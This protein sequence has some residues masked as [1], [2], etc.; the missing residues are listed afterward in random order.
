[1]NLWNMMT[2]M[3]KEDVFKKFAEDLSTAIPEHT[4]A[5]LSRNQQTG[6]YQ[7]SPGN[8]QTDVP[9]KN[10]IDGADP[11]LRRLLVGEQWVHWTIAQS[12]PG[13]AKG[14]DPIAA[15]V[16]PIAVHGQIDHVLVVSGGNLSESD[17][18]MIGGYCRQ[19]ALALE[20]LDMQASLKL[21][22]ERLASLVGTVDDSTTE[23]SYQNLL[24]TILDRSAELLLAEQGSIMLIEKETDELLLE[25]SRGLHKEP[26]Q[27]GRVP[28]GIGIAG[29]V[30]KL[31][32]P[33]L[34]EDVEQ[35]PRIGK[36]NQAK[37]KTPSFVSVPLKIGN[38]VVGVMNF[39]DKT[40]GDYFDDVDLRFARHVR[41]MRPSYSITGICLKS[42][43]S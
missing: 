25:A 35:D 20:T 22:I 34:V 11:V 12:L 1:M 42:R 31:G 13:D 8:Q 27:K 38:R 15:V 3:S 30:A 43:R 21:K 36:K 10:H 14:R 41:R 5:I 29:M 7:A 17:I 6:S 23:Q 2:H 19:T 18:R 26:T 40:T 24:Q 16:F 4:I 39:T 33:I 9:G 32:E 28:K 37:Y